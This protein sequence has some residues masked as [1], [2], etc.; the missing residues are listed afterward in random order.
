[1]RSS[2]HCAD[3]IYFVLILD[4]TATTDLEVDQVGVMTTF[5]DGALKDEIYMEQIEDFKHKQRQ[6]NTW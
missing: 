6:R 4:V 1:M 3:I 5:L 2:N